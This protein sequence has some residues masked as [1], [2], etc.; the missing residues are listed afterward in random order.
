MGARNIILVG[1]PGSGKSTVGVLLAKRTTRRF[2]D[3]DIL[4][5]LREHRSLQEI[6]NAEGYMRLREIEAEVIS[7]FQGEGCVVATG[8]SAPYCPRA[9]ATLQR[10]GVVVFL[11]V[12]VPTLRGRI[13]DYET[14]GIAK[15]R[16]QSFDELFAERQALYIKY[17]DITIDCDALKQDETCQA[18]LEELREGQAQFT[19]ES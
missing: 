16:D 15:P 12:S 8:G 5:Q 10:G 9:M 6:M 13:T 2:V 7:A 3:T 18:V 4:I 11:K 19:P 14:R 17:A 1:M